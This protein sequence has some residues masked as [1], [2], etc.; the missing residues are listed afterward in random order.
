MKE[1]KKKEIIDFITAFIFLIMI[2]IYLRS[3]AIPQN[4]QNQN[5]KRVP[6]ALKK[7]LQFFFFLGHQ[8]F[9]KK[10]EL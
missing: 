2:A 8:Q 9:R 4:H 5:Q 10:L 3:C 1:K 7:L 6:R